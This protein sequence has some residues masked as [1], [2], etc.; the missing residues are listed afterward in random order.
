[1]NE[2]RK[3]ATCPECGNIGKL[4]VV[5]SWLEVFSNPYDYDAYT[6]KDNNDWQLLYCPVCYNVCLNKVRII[7]TTDAEEEKITEEIVFPNKIKQFNNTPAKIIDKY[8]ALIKV[9]YTESETA[10]VVMRKILEMI[11]KD[12]GA[13]GRDLYYKID[14]ISQQNMMP[15]PLVKCLNIVRELGNRAAHVETT[16]TSEAISKQLKEKEPT[17]TETPYSALRMTPSRNMKCSGA[18]TSRRRRARSTGTKCGRPAA[19]LC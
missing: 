19:T 6:L 9:I 18:W 16:K 17:K 1:M 15:V 11:C 12:I 3:I 4:N 7:K 10:L 2:K 8:K 13:E 14:Y 5:A